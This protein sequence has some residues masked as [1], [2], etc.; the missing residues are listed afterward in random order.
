M[1]KRTEVVK[2]LAAINFK[3]DLYTVLNAEDA[4]QK[5]ND[6]VPTL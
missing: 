2:R 6:E 1:I 5:R 4:F 3:S